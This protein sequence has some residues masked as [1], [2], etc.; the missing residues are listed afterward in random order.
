MSIQV[1]QMR[2]RISQITKAGLVPTRL[3]VSPTVWGQINRQTIQG[4]FKK[5]PVKV[6][7][8][9]SKDSCFWAVLV[10]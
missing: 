2:R 8:P 4:H 7:S 5:V 3:Y 10:A 6:V 9:P 1:D